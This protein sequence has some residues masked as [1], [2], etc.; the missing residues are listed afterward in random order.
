M[1]A[2]NT[3]LEGKWF[4]LQ[5]LGFVSDEP[6]FCYFGSVTSFYLFFKYSTQLRSLLYT[7][8]CTNIKCIA[9]VFRYVYTYVT[10]YTISP[11]PE[12]NHYSD[13]WHYELILSLKIHI[14]GITQHL[15]FVLFF[16]CLILFIEMSLKFVHVIVYIRLEVCSF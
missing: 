6:G 12:Y 9:I 5:I 4:Y 16:V 14:S 10:T 7:V 1:E 11:S 8:K 3:Q 2:V 13:F 15:G